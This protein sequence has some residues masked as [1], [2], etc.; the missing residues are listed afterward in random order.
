[1]GITR[2]S[3]LVLIVEEDFDQV[4]LVKQALKEMNAHAIITNNLEDGLSFLM[5]T[6]SVIAGA[7]TSIYYPSADGMDDGRDDIDNPKGLKFIEACVIKGV[8]VA[9]CSNSDH[10]FEGR[11]KE[12]E[13]NPKYHGKTIF[14]SLGT[15]DWKSSV[16]NLLKP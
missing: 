16:Y 8:K 2:K 5:S 9:V 1:M 7:I 4:K 13:A 10:N 3:P 14:L 6:H 12:F 15:K 11:I